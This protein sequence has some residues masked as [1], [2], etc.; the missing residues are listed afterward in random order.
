MIEVE[1]EDEAWSRAVPDWELL[2]IQ[3][4]ERAL[5]TAPDQAALD[6]AILLADDETVRD[7]NDRFRHKNTPTNVLSFPANETAA[8]HLGDIVLA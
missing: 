8:G 1:A 3:A 7:L 2:C 5:G 4:A 6:I